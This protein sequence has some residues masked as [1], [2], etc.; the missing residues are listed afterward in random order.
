[1]EGFGGIRAIPTTFIIDKKGNIQEKLVG[2]ND[3]ETFEKIIQKLL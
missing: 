3:K 1:V 2:Y